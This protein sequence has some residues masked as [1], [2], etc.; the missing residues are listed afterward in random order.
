MF[1]R[2]VWL[3][4]LL[5][6]LHAGAQSVWP[7]A[8]ESPRSDALNALSGATVVSAL[9]RPIEIGI[10]TLPN[11]LQ[12]KRALNETMLR[13]R[14]AFAPHAVHAEV[15][16]TATLEKRISQGTIDAF[17][18]SAGYFVRMM[19]HGAIHVGTLISDAAPDPNNT[20]AG[21][22]VVR[23]NDHRVDSLED[24]QGKSL[25]ASYETAFMGFRTGMAEIAALGHDPEHFFSR[26]D[27]TGRTSNYEILQKLSSRSTDA[28]LIASCWF[29]DLP[30]AERS[31][32]R[33][34]NPRKDSLACLHSTRTY[35]GIT[36]AVTQSAPP[37]VAHLIS[38]T[39][40]SMD[41]LS[42]G[43]RW[44]IATD[45]RAVDRLYKELRIEHYSYLREWSVKR[46]VRTYWYWLAIA[47]L[48]VLGLAAHSWRVS[49]LV[50]RRTR[51]LMRTME[52]KRIAQMKADAFRE[53][54]QKLQKTMLI[55]QLSSMIAHELSQPLAA[56]RY[57]CE[58]EKA[59]LASSE[60]PN[61]DMLKKAESGIEN[62]LATVT[63]IVE[64][65]RSYNK[66]QAKR[67]SAVDLQNCLQSA[68][69]GVNAKLLS[70][71]HVTISGV[72]H[73]AV[74]ADPLEAEIL[75]HNL[76]K[77]A[78]E[79]AQE[80]HAPAQVRLTAE[81]TDDRVC[82]TIENSGLVLDESAYLRLTTPLVT[83]KET[84]TGLG[85]P[86]AL[87][88]AEASGG[89][90]AFERRTEGGLRAVVTLNP[91]ETAE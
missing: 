5:L 62:A 37:G 74:Q 28:A 2:L 19:P 66:G 25:A 57:Y 33:P 30:E 63:A 80:G 73:L 77:N 48:I 60:H 72:E 81:Q 26:I 71:T 42:G 85:V 7:G 11:R 75:F 34:I 36:F 13:L 89:H 47:A 82:V 68:V 31:R 43:Y 64:K 84:G 69:Q 88:L 1:A 56:I 59:L 32:Y 91:A 27:F 38:K 29:D 76:I 23:R 10:I 90:I 44:G 20:V 87:A 24:L 18:A 58:G 41:K 39:L 9:S 3:V 35:P 79:A 78:V 50:R 46:W 6:P 83:T 67:D 16:D 49:V 52:E 70:V 51:D 65:V 22:F 15:L 86:I 8:Q 54:E 55:G 14:S 40:M 17:V 12:T 53:R 21:L 45:M 61:T 4:F